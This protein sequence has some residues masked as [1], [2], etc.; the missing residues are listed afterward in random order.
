MNPYCVLEQA[1]VMWP[2]AAPNFCFRVQK[3]APGWLYIHQKAKQT[4]SPNPDNNQTDFKLLMTYVCM[5]ACMH[6]RIFSYFVVSA[7]GIR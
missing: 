3:Y 2:S 6:V 7:R 4:K 5:L 1:A